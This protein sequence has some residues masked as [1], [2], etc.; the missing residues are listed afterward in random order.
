M[1]DLL[2]AGRIYTMDPANPV[3]EGALV[4]EGRFVHVG[5]LAE[6]ALRA[7]PG[8]GRL[9]IGR[10]SATA[11]LCDAHG[12]VLWYGRSLI[13]LS[14]AGLSD[15]AACVERVAAASL[16]VPPGQWIRGH[17]WDHNLW[18][19]TRFPTLARL[20]AAT[21]R[22][23]VALERADGHALWANALALKLCGIRDDT[24]DPAGGRILRAPDGSPTGVFIDN[25]AD[26]VLRNIPPLSRSEV[27]AALVVALS[28]LARA[29]LTAVHD[30]GVSPD[31]LEVYRQLALEDRLPLRVYGMIDGQSP[32]EQVEQQ[33]AC[34]RRTPQ[35]G[36]LEVRAVKFFADGALA[37]RGAA[38]FEPYDD[39]PGN[40]GLF[41]TAPDELRR[42]IAVVL[43][44][45]FQPAVHAI[46]DW[47]C[48]E[49]LKAFAA[50]EKAQLQRGQLR[51]EHLQVL[52]PRDVQLLA[53]V[54]ASM[55]PIHAVNDAAWAERRL[56]RGTA[57][58][59]GAYAWRQAL[60][61][62]AVLAFGSDFPVESFDVRQGLLAAE[63]RVPRGASLP[64]MPEQRLTR[65]EALEAYTVGAAIAGL[66]GRRRGMVRAGHD[67]DLTV[68]AGDILAASVEEL[69]SLAI[70]H[71]V[72]SGIVA[73]V[74]ARGR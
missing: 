48:A 46:G 64:W 5:S 45:G 27:E 16:K 44:A 57:R 36:R 38:L 24:R 74:G 23:P 8:A 22:H 39:D 69:P 40:R 52:L 65:Q 30:A 25:A 9:E 73:P 7:R 1:Q 71:T 3:A 67:A 50:V 6:C 56:G 53:G 41:V 12:H 14:C 28:E 59:A 68:F 54:V 33:M 58:Q 34:W 31:G 72:V 47:A 13:E 21:P 60:Q 61:G 62:G 66:A 19:E 35:V 42:R 49:V 51:V 70:T 55:Q 18:P 20:S 29:G 4:R 26:L 15:E 10:G 2:V 11:G 63:L 37:S 43:R 17:G 32:L